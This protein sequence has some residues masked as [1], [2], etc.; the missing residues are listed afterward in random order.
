[1]HR[2]FFPLIAHLQQLLASTSAAISLLAR[3]RDSEEG[4]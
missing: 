2:N 4:I 1:M 3:Y